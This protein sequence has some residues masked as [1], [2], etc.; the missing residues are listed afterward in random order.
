MINKLYETPEQA[1]ADV[2][3][4]ATVLIGGFGEAGS[5]IELVH[6]LLTRE[7]EISLSSTTIPEAVMLGWQR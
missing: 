3:D 2:F 4:G 1:V 6:A 7:P 5:P